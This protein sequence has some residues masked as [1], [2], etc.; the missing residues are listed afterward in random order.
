MMKK[1]EEARRVRWSKCPQMLKDFYTEH[2]EVTEMTEEEVELFRENN[3]KIRITRDFAKDDNSTKAPMPKP[4]TKFIHAFD[5]Y[6]EILNEIKKNGFERPSP[7]Q[8]QMWP[9]LLKGDDCIGIAQ[10][11][12]GKTLGKLIF[13][14]H[15]YCVSFNFELIVFGFVSIF[16][17][18]FNSY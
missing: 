15:Y 1:S 13:E 5:N 12:T 8:S 18:S 14:N 16:A 4:T 3:M 10:T 2:H 6:P 7:I 11:G 17:S 9:I